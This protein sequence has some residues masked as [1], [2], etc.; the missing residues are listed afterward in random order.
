MCGGLA[1]VVAG[2]RVMAEDRMCVGLRSTQRARMRSRNECR[3]YHSYHGGQ[4][5]LGTA[6]CWAACSQSRIYLTLGTTPSGRCL[7]APT[8]ESRGS[9]NTSL[10]RPLHPSR[11][12]AWVESE[13]R[14]W[15]PVLCAADAVGCGI[16]W[17]GRS[18]SLSLSSGSP[19]PLS[20]LSPSWSPPREAGG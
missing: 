16:V 7:L 18:P 12:E 3:Y 17:S 8:S 10:A 6:L 19:P 14:I 15:Q 1:T 5:L 9:W 11:R 20:P 4:C 2:M 13:C